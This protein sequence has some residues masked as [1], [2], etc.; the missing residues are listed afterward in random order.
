MDLA[1]LPINVQRRISLLLAEKTDA[2]APPV[3]PLSWPDPPVVDQAAAATP[4]RSQKEAGNHDNIQ[5]WSF[6]VH[7]LASQ[8]HQQPVIAVNRA[9]LGPGKLQARY[10]C[11][12]KHAEQLLC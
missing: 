12:H 11:S 7:A 10:D 4:Y 6:P 9:V 8:L 5:P 2:Q 3:T 1:S